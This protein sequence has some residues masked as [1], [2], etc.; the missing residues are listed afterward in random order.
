MKAKYLSFMLILLLGCSAEKRNLKNLEIQKQLIEAIE[1]NPPRVS[2]ILG[3]GAGLFSSWVYGGEESISEIQLKV[4]YLDESGGIL[5]EDGVS[6]FPS[7]QQIL[8]EEQ[9]FCY[10]INTGYINDTD[11]YRLEVRHVEVE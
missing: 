2:N 8:S 4:F 5:F 7:P 11:S 10:K 6:I 3:G 9:V 1:M